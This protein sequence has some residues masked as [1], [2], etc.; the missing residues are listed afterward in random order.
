MKML[1]TQS[2]PALC[3]S[4]YSSPP[5]SSVHRILQAKILEW[6]AILFS[7]GSFQ[8]GDQ[9]RVSYTGS[10]Y[11]F[12]DSVGLDFELLACRTNENKF[13]ILGYQ[14]CSNLL[15]QPQE[16]VEDVGSHYQT[17]YISPSPTPTTCTC[18]RRNYDGPSSRGSNG[19]LEQGLLCR[20]VS[21]RSESKGLSEETDLATG[22]G[23]T[24]R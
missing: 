12:R 16:G 3:D 14:V 4:M 5:A 19:S 15:Q 8:P 11:S 18:G 13:V 1:A 9:A 6:I 10:I 22:K 2:C 23:G 17:I 7:R 21:C 24:P 20:Q